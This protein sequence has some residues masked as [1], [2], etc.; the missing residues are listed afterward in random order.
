MHFVTRNILFIIHK[1]TLK[2]SLNFALYIVTVD[3]ERMT[4]HVLGNP[5]LGV[6]FHLWFLKHHNEGTMLHSHLPLYT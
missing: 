5:D 1:K 4:E 3:V 2:I 6:V